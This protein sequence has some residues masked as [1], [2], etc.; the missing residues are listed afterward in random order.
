[1]TH[2][3]SRRIHLSPL[4]CMNRTQQ[5]LDG[6]PEAAAALAC[7]CGS[8]VR[9]RRR[10]VPWSKPL[11]APS[12]QLHQLL[13]VDAHFHFCHGQTD[14]ETTCCSQW[15]AKKAEMSC[16]LYSRLDGGF[17]LSSEEASVITKVQNYLI[18]PQITRFSQK[19]LRRVHQ[20]TPLI[21]RGILNILSLEIRKYLYWLCQ[22]DTSKVHEYMHQVFN[23]P[24]TFITPLSALHCYQ[25]SWQVIVLAVN[26]SAN[27]RRLPRFDMCTKR[28]ISCSNYVLIS[29]LLHKDMDG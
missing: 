17:Y 4:N 24:L 1:M 21:L 12:T 3:H 22:F 19:P 29:H 2:I 14:W 15:D 18:Q 26:V 23:C 13:C 28:G 5:T 20:I 9:M 7:P 6:R 27:H 16:F 25:P 11:T 10:P 8:A